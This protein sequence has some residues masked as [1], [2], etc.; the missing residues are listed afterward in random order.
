MEDLE[1]PKRQTSLDGEAI[2]IVIHDVD[3]GPLCASKRR[4][5]LRRDPSDKAHRSE[6]KND[7]IFTCHLTLAIFITCLARGFGMRVVGGKTGADGKLFAHIVWTVPGGPAEKGGLQQGDKILEWCGVSLVD[8][9]FEEVCSIMD[10]TADIAELLV[11]HASDFR[12]CDLLEDNNGQQ[13]A[14]LNSQGSL[15]NPVTGMSSR[16]NSDV[17]LIPGELL[18]RNK[19]A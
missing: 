17:G 5:I 14:A 13:Q 18:K 8:R 11:E 4:I 9:S 15:S 16:K 10:R 3:S 1:A 12:M 2:K 7:K 6:L 19:S